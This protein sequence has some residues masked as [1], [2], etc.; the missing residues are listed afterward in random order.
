[1]IFQQQL[2]GD[3]KIINEPLP[4]E[5]S[6]VEENAI[7]FAAGVLDGHYGHHKCGCSFTK[8]Y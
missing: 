6:L 4:D 5:E 8:W 3:G 2:G 7:S 1:M